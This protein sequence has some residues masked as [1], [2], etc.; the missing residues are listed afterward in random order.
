MNDFELTVPDLYVNSTKHFEIFCI[1]SVTSLKD[2]ILDFL[3]CQKKSYVSN[4]FRS[5]YNSYIPS[6]FK[7]F[8]FGFT[9]KHCKIKIT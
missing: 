9:I 7:Y 4:K 1:V 6:L 8:C 2:N 3:T 5:P